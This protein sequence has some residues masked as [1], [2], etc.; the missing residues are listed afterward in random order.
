M[1]DIIILGKPRSGKSTLA[2][3]LVDRYGYQII[4]MD[5]LRNAFRDIFPELEIAPNTAINNEKWYEFLEKYYERLK[6]CSRYQ[7][8]FI[9]EGCEMH[10]KK[11]VELFSDKDNLIYVLGQI[12][13]SPRN[14][15]DNIV[16]YDTK[17][18]WT[19][20]YTYKELLEYCENSINQAK[21]LKKECIKCGIPFFDTGKDREKVLNEI[22]KDIKEKCTL[23]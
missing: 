21:E 1:K 12:N 13:L 7:H 17:D 14:M 2:D 9:I 11:C 8:K 15:A 5:A 22:E 6:R 3:R 18:D 4:R 23:I 10:V 20:T 16:K 19:R